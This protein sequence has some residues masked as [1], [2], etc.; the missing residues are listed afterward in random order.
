L[1]FNPVFVTEVVLEFVILL[2][3]TPCVKA[4]SVANCTTYPE[5]PEVLVQDTLIAPV[6]AFTAVN[7]DGIAGGGGTATLAVF[8]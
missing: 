4:A 2:D 3:V 5:T 6:P 8:E 7:P 1:L